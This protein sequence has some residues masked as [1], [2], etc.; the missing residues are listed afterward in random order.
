MLEVPSEQGAH[1]CTSCPAPGLLRSGPAPLSVK[2]SCIV[3]PFAAGLNSW[4]G[5]QPGHGKTTTS[6]SNGALQRV[7]QSFGTKPFPVVL[8]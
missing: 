6:Y 4:Q 5:L 3:K 1:A 7:K 8:A 2:C